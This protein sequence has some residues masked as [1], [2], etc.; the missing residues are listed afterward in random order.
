ME[1]LDNSKWT[2][3]NLD[4]DKFRNGDIIPEAKTLSDFQLAGENE[5]PAWCYY[6][7]SPV[8]GKVYGKLY[9]WYAVNDPRGLAP[10]GYHIPT[11]DEWT[12]LENLLGEDAGLKLKSKNGWGY[13]DSG[14]GTDLIGFNALPSG[15]KQEGGFFD[16]IVESSFFWSATQIDNDDAYLRILHDDSPRVSRDSKGW[17]KGFGASVRCVKD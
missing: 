11:N 15:Y 16:G 17:G 14:N 3:K 13:W 4:V 12:D 9:N 10:E 5:T 8:N 2:S 6:D 1:N 7:N